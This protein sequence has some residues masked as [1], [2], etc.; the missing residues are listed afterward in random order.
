MVFVNEKISIQN[1]WEKFPLATA[2]PLQRTTSAGFFSNLKVVKTRRR[3]NTAEKSPGTSPTRPTRT[4]ATSKLVFFRPLT[5]SKYHVWPS[6]LLRDVGQINS[7]YK[8]Y[9]MARVEGIYTV[10]GDPD[11]E[12]EAYMVVSRSRAT[13]STVAQLLFFAVATN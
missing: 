3:S 4:D 12:W 6:P 10:R 11:L 7:L 1:L 5:S 13:I 2:V 8:W 9:R